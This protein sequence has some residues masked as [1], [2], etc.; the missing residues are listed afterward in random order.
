M[1]RIW[2]LLLIIS[3]LFLSGCDA[4]PVTESLILVSIVE[5]EG[6]TVE[7]NGQLVLPGQDAVFVLT[8]DRGIS[9][10]D[11]DYPGATQMDV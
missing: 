10:T 7:N 8:F 11:T 5:G 1:K 9:M 4:P 6:Y 3:G 2:L